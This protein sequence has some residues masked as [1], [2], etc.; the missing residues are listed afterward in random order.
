MKRAPYSLE[1]KIRDEK[2][3]KIFEWRYGKANLL[4]GLSVT[5]YFIMKKLGIDRE[6]LEQRCK[7]LEEASNE[8][9]IGKKRR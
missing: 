7:Q 4:M 3:K 5:E 9:L 8:M 1:V 2:G 6:T